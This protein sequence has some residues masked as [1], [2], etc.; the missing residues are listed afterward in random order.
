MTKRI[1]L[2]NKD[3]EL[4]EWFNH[5][6]QTYQTALEEVKPLKPIKKVE[7]NKEGV[8]VAVYYSTTMA[9]DILNIE[10]ELTDKQ[11]TAISEAIKAVMEYIQEDYDS[12][13]L[14][15]YIQEDAFKAR[16]LMQKEES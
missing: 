11:A 13:D 14:L 1:T 10:L 15:S 16:E 5:E 9:K 8:C 7:E 12:G 4:V 6:T 3:Y 2:G